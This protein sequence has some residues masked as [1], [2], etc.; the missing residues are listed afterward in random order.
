MSGFKIKVPASS[1]NIGPGFDVLG[2][3]LQLYLELKV[4]IE[5]EIDTS[6]DPYH[7]LLTYEGDLAANVPLSSDKNLVTQSALYVLRCNGID[8]FPSG[9]HIHVTNPIP[10]GRGLG[11]SASAIVGGVVLGNEIAKLGFDK[12]RLLDYCLMI[13]R[14]PDNIAAAMLGGFIGSYLNEMELEHMEHKN[15]PLECILPRPSTPQ[16]M[17]VSK[18]PPM[19]I[20]EYLQYDW[21]KKI[22][23]VTVIPNFELSTDSARAVLPESYNRED[24]VYNLQRIAILTSALTQSNPNNKLIYQAMKDKIHQPYRASLIPGLQQ[25][26][27]SITP[28]SHPGL[29]GIC[30]S[31]AGPTILCLATEGFDEIANSVIE[32]FKQAGVQCDWKLLDLAYDGATVEQ[33]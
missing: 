26:L 20:G 28:L 5:P 30:L 33:L 24:I 15:V 3:G 32:I 12:I 13:E 11:S 4:T 1:A 21:C 18:Q 31:G 27:D 10:L 2:I 9:T 16:D 6:S 8:K 17:I 29:C 7:V 25:V 23:C 14:H 19:N 22:K